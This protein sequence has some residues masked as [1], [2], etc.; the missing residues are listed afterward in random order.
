VTWKAIGAA[1]ALTLALAAFADPHDAGAQTRTGSDADAGRELFLTGC[2]SCHGQEG[3]GV[4]DRGP[5]LTDS[6]EAAAYYYLHTGRMPLAN[7]EETPRR[8]EPAYDDDQIAALV[9]FV[10]SLGHGPPLPDVDP[11]AGNLAEGGELYRGNCAPCHSAAGVGGA[12]SYGRA[13]PN[14]HPADPNE[15]AAAVRAGPGQMPVFGDELFD[16]EQLD[17]LIRYVD[18]LDQPDDRGG[19][20]LGRVG[21][22]P[23]GFVTWVIG[24]GTLLGV[25]AWIGTRR[26]DED[27]T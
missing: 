24:I 15:I 16:Q 21:P 3:G 6:G 14:I 1:L 19:L 25:V 11:R 23:E 4:A 8:K 12:L 10:G 17:S 18:Y 7:S 22:I 27:A 9:A 26:R 13:A 20:P 5:A 2:S